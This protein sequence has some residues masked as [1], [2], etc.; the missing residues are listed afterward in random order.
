MLDIITQ[1]IYQDEH[2]V[3][4]CPGT[5]SKTLQF[6]AEHFIEAYQKSVDDHDAF[7]L[8]LS[9]G[10]TPK[11]LFQLLTSAPYKEKIDW[12]KIHLFWSDERS[13]PPDHS[14]SNYKMA[15]DAGFSLVPKENIHRMIAEKDIE[16]G[17]AAYQNCILTVL[18]NKAFDYIMLGLGDDGHTASLFPSTLGLEEK[19]KLVVANYVKEKK[20]W[21]MTLTYPC[22]NKAL[23]IAVYILGK[24][25]QEI[26]SNV[27]KEHA[28]PI[29]YPILGVGTAASK[30]LWILDD[31]AATLIKHR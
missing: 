6:C 12:S 7:F 19:N 9:G 27:L 22:I 21:R 8:A 5:Y 24:S 14:D 26:L 20:T 2:K 15:M 10:S 3:L 1:S 13:V 29:L 30:A 17:A 28:S 16:T 18:E 11:A 31:D 23:H 25:K 4:I